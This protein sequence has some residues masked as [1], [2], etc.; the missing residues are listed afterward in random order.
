MKQNYLAFKTQCLIV[1]SQIH[2]ELE[3]LYRMSSMNEELERNKS[4]LEKLYTIIQTIYHK[5][6]RKN[7]Y[8]EELQTYKDYTHYTK[9]ILEFI[10]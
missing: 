3:S 6:S 9:Y 2:M 8:I 5:P 7:E 10:E 4:N 1:L